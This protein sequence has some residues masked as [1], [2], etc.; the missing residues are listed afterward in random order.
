MHGE[1]E[2]R[3]AVK[4]P[5]ERQ[6]DCTG[7]FVVCQSVCARLRFIIRSVKLR[8]PKLAVGRLFRRTS[9]NCM[10]E[11]KRVTNSNF[12]QLAE[13]VEKHVKTTKITAQS[14]ADYLDEQGF[15]RTEGIVR[16]VQRAAKIRREA[17]LVEIA[18]EVAKVLPI[19]PPRT[20]VATYIKSL[21]HDVSNKQVMKIY[22]QLK[23]FPDLFINLD[24]LK[25]S[26][27]QHY[28]FLDIRSHFD[29]MIIREISKST[30]LSEKESVSLALRVF[31]QSFSLYNIPLESIITNGMSEGEV[32][33]SSYLKLLERIDVSGW[34]KVKK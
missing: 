33:I 14:V 18:E 24:H 28:P 5:H 9:T 12:E 8:Y 3:F 16:R 30:G 19:N 25:G 10:T 32:K 2:V 17:Y 23:S 13:L 21:G 7:V 27:S 22:S 26:S 31:L 20:V 15:L 4:V 6:S 1:I 29:Y 34:V 11:K